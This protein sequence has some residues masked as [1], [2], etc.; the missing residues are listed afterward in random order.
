MRNG[1]FTAKEQLY[2]KSLPV[3]K[4]VTATRIRYTEQFRVETMLRY[5]DGES[6]VAIFR[7]AGLDS[8]L[9]GYKRIERCIARWRHE[10]KS[11]AAVGGSGDGAGNADLREQATVLTS[12]RGRAD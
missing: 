8:Q 1:K 3:V 5:D 9:I 11:A 10:G 4:S 2:L 12:R 7:D 6:P